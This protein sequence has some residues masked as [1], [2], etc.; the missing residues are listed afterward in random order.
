MGSSANV[1]GLQSVITGITT[2]F[3][4]GLVTGGP[5]GM[6]IEIEDLNGTLADSDSYV[7][8][9]DCGFFLHH[10]CSSGHGGDCQRNSYCR[11]AILLVRLLAFALYVMI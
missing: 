8:W 10:V 2:L 3:E 6:L 1:F 11:R 7:Y 4:Y 5:G 9:M